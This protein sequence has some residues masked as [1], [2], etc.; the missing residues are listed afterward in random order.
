M[1]IPAA[2]SITTWFTLD[3]DVDQDLFYA[4][5]Q[6]LESNMRERLTANRTYYVRT[7]GSNSNTG[8]VNS[9]G[10][11]FLTL[12]KALSVAYYDIDTGNFI[13]TI[14]V[15]AGTYTEL[16]VLNGA[17]S[18]NRVLVCIKLWEV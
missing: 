13:A 16:V 4:W 5:A 2:S 14:Q 6:A 9:A 11:A 18:N 12:Q 10:G 17:A 8:L 15:A 7:D 1:A 3:A